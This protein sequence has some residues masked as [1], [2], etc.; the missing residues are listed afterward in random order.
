V[1]ILDLLYQSLQLWFVMPF[2]RIIVADSQFYSLRIMENEFF[3]ITLTCDGDFVVPRNP[4]GI[5][6][7]PIT[8]G[9]NQACTFY[10]ATPGSATISGRDYLSAGY[11]LDRNDIL[12][13]H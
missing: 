6:K 13:V 12:L 4:P 3:R 8:I 9:P 5:D 7:Y 1:V 11:N 2:F 10:G